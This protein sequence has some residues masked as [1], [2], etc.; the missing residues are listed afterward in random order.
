M[1]VVD[2]TD[3]TFE[4]E[5]LGADKPVIVDFWAPWCVPCRRVSPILDEMSEDRDDVRFV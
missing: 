4:Q 3:A 2:V 5:V 1:A